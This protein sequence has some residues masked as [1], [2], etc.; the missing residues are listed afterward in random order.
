MFLWESSDKQTPATPET[1]LA[2]RDAPVLPSPAPHA[3]LGTDILAEP[4][5]DQEVLYL[6]SGCF[7]GA[8]KLAWELGADA[9]AVGYMG[10]FTPNPTY[11]E[12]CTG[13]TGHTETVR[14]LYAPSRLP[15]ERLLQAFFESH[16][17]TSLNRQGGD[18]GTQYRSAIFPTTSQQEEL[19]RRMIKAYQEVLEN[20][21]FGKIVTEVTPALEAAPFYPAEDWHQQYLDKNPNGY[22]CHARTG[23]ACP[24]PGAG[25]V[26]KVE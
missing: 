7:W 10:G 3:V 12:V 20:N 1:A 8:E 15:T 5:P 13:K 2:G 11:E 17:P 6:A 18:I 19:A 16:D 9:T 23:M 14:V 4:G 24:L 21:G 26:A 22:Q 25:P